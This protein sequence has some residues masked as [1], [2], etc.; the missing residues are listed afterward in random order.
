MPRKSET[1]AD[2]LF[3]AMSHASDALIDAMEKANQRG[4]RVSKTT[5]REAR[6]GGREVLA[7]TR[8]WSARP[9]DVTQLYEAQL[10]V[11]TRGLELVRQWLDEAGGVQTDVREALQRLVIANIAAGQAVSAMVRRSPAGAPPAGA[12]EKKKGAARRRATSKAAATRAPRGA[13]AKAAGPAPARRTAAPKKAAATTSRPRRS[14][15]PAT[16]SPGARAPATE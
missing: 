15:A 7:M 14:R 1:P 3:A 12:S 2:R 11:Q 13:T 9:A 10:D 5:I 16:S 6:K 8:K 4:Y